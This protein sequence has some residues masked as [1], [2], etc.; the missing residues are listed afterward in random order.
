MRALVTG[1]TGCV[2]ANVVA[3]LLERGYAV[4]G[5]RRPTST[6]RALDGLNVELVIG[7]LLEPESLTRA[8][9]G[10]DLV[11]HVAAISDYWRTPEEII[12]RVNVG[13][14]K[15][16]V[17]AALEA[18]VE[19]LVYTSSSAALGVAPQGELLNEEDTFNLP[20]HRFPYG[21]SKHLAEGVVREAVAQ[22]LDAVIVNPAIVI[23]P[24]DVNWIAG[25]M[26]KEVRKDLVWVAPPGGVCWVD[27]VDLGR[28]QVLAAERG[29]T[30]ERYLL[31][32]E[33]LSHRQSLE[34][35]AEVVGGRPPCVT[36]PPL[37]MRVVSTAARALNR[38][39]CSLAFSSEQAWLSTHHLYCDASKAVRELGHV[40]TSFRTS[41]EQA[42]AWYRHQ[43]MLD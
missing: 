10:C 43:G 4:R 11:F 34:T 40:Q 39:G 30:G 12:Y 32:S 42:F 41:V 3:A 36:L 20:P 9:E 1:S 31:G 7:D 38:L 16:V 21:H 5:L 27:A 24:R 29:R 18:G 14:T 13:G 6:L 15:N 17:E 8:M 28:A 35:M 37:V 26:M 33:N 23:G 22:R 2:G 25:S 19:R